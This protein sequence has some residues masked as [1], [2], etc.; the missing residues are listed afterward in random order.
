MSLEYKVKFWTSNRWLS[1]WIVQHITLLY[2]I[3]SPP[4][5]T[6]KFRSVFN[7]S[8]VM[9]IWLVILNVE[10]SDKRRF[11]Q[12]EHQNSW[13]STFLGFPSY[14]LCTF[15]STSITNQLKTSSDEINIMSL[16]KLMNPVN[17][18]KHKE[19][20]PLFFIIYIC[21]S[22]AGTMGA[23]EMSTRCRSSFIQRDRNQTERRNV[24]QVGST[25]E[26]NVFTGVCHSV[27]G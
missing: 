26:G 3:G 16:T 19:V 4:A 22:L 21:S 18:N 27:H 12:R 8:H 5:V 2:G 20:H 14:W 1:W 17:N 15:S 6:I 11:V 23:L 9:L 24:N 10:Q 25:R 13:L 7:A